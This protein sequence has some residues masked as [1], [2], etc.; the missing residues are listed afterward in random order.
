MV[1]ANYLHR[2]TTVIDAL[3]MGA[4]QR[5]LKTFRA[6]RPK[7][8]AGEWFL[9]WVNTLVYNPK[10]FCDFLA[11]NNI[12]LLDGSPHS[13]DLDPISFFPF[14]KLKKG[15]DRHHHD[16]GGVQEQEGGGAEDPEQRGLCQGHHKMV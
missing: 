9:H 10:T 11:Q 16:P 13:S 3:N 1:Y 6:K 12:K 8:V 15:V 4:L 2:G 7:T 5:F 14:P